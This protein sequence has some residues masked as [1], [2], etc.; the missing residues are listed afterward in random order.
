MKELSLHHSNV[1]KVNVSS[2][3]TDLILNPPIT[4]PNYLPSTIL[5]V[6]D[7]KDLSL[8]EPPTF[9]SDQKSARRE[10]FFLVLS[11]VR[12]QC[13]HLNTRFMQGY[14]KLFE[15]TCYSYTTSCCGV[16]RI[17]EAVIQL[18]AEA[19]PRLLIE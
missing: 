2:V 17:H 1:V 9:T 15:G 10:D 13:I 12:K 5:S 19:Q 4:L 6:E 16:S 11:P 7:C 14:T 8:G 3:G 18:V